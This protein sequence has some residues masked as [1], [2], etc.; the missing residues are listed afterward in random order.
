[1]VLLES[2]LAIFQEWSWISSHEDCQLGWEVHTWSIQPTVWQHSSYDRILLHEQVADQGKWEHISSPPTRQWVQ[3]MMQASCWGV[4]KTL[5]CSALYVLLFVSVGSETF[6]VCCFSFWWVHNDELVRVIDQDKVRVID[7]R[8]SCCIAARW[9]WPY[10]VS[11]PQFFADI[12]FSSLSFQSAERFNVVDIEIE[13]WEDI[14]VCS[15]DFFLVIV[16]NV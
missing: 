4:Y 10:G 1:M 6:S 15:V 13:K 2:M 16:I 7:Q 3:P 14:N 12:R 5:L 11:W 9:F 8:V